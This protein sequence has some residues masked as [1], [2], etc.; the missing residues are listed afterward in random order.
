MANHITVR[1]APTSDDAPP[2]IHLGGTDRDIPVVEWSE[3]PFT[4][5]SIELGNHPDPAAYLREL[6]LSLV[7]LVNLVDGEAAA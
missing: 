3:G 4:R 6:A 7:N 1:L 5:V 2:R